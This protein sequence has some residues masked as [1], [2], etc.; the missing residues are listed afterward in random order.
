MT[1]GHKHVVDGSDDSSGSSSEVK[2][3]GLWGDCEELLQGCCFLAAFIPLSTRSTSSRSSSVRLRYEGWLL[4]RSEKRR[5]GARGGASSSLK[6]TSWHLLVQTS[7]FL[8]PSS[9]K[10]PPLF[11]SSSSVVQFF[12][13][14]SSAPCRDTHRPTLFYFF[15]SAEW[16]GKW[17]PCSSPLLPIQG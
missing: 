4:E 1:E 14:W 15:F 2:A 8:F 9:D 7:F 16:S 5:G 6:A 3:P 17:Q 13:T 12:G 10:S 11:F